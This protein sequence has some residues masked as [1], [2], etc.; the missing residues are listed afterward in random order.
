MPHLLEGQFVNGRG[1]QL[2]TVTWTP[3]AQPVAKIVFHHG[4]GEHVRRYDAVFE[5]IA[6]EGIAVYSYDCHGH[7]RS[8]PKADNERFLVH[9]FK[10]LLDDYEAFIR[11]VRQQQPTSVPLFAMGHSM[12]GLV[13]VEGVLRDQSLAQGLILSGAA[14]FVQFN[15]VLRVQAAISGLLS[16]AMPYVRM[17]PAVDVNHL[18]PEPELVQAYK[19]DPLID[20]SNMR[21]RTARELLMAMRDVEHSG[22]NL[23]LPLFAFHGADDKV[24]SPLGTRRLVDECCSKDKELLE[25]AGGYH[26]LLANPAH[27]P[28][29]VGRVAS[30]IVQRASGAPGPAAADGDGSGGA[31]SLGKL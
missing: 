15:A 1:Q 29:L 28:G 26:E 24:T 9:S 14:L 18:N 12:G 17:V 27:R 7:G 5:A 16:A 8:Q 20:H 30:W 22:R 11:H 21:V 19:D 25:V 4:Y 10:H 6:A 13:A 3:D 23:A 31:P 2:Y